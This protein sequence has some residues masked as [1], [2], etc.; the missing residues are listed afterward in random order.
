MSITNEVFQTLVCSVD[1]E[2]EHI[3][4]DPILLP[5]GHNACRKCIDNK[6]GKPIECFFD[7]CNKVYRFDETFQMSNNKTI[8]ALIKNYLKDLYNIMHD[9]VKETFDNFD[10][11]FNLVNLNLKNLNFS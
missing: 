4:E 7:D 2:E 6:N 5:C 1:D 11:N 8:E 9:R 3:I 10:S